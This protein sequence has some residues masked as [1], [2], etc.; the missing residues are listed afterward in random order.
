ME[1]V[2]TDKALIEQSDYILSIVPPRDAFSVACRMKNGLQNAKRQ[3][4][5]PLY[6]LD[7][8]A[9]SPLTAQMIAKELSTSHGV[10][11]LDG[12]IIGGPPK[13]NMPSDT[14]TSWYRPSIVVSGEKRL[15]DAPVSG[16][17]L[18]DILNVKHVADKIGPASGL[19]MCFASMNKGF[20]AIAIEAFTAAE[21]MGVL[22]E[23]QAHLKEYS[24]GLGAA[25]AKSLVG[26]P[27]KAYRWVAEMEEIAVT[28]EKFGGFKSRTKAVQG[29][30]E[31]T[32]RAEGG[33]GE[34]TARGSGGDL[35]RGVSDVYRFVAEDT[36]L[37]NEKTESRTKGQTPEDVARLC[38]K[39]LDGQRL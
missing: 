11:L 12:G 20:T 15:Q 29:T 30:Q 39:E 13:S 35:F 27:P 14:Y 6:F 37:G 21:N 2:P 9:V 8:N 34:A 17:H 19:K 22:P 23:L 5:T 1:L 16:S 32:V 26:M 38:A 10:C 36:E 25:A 24:P 31:D 7:L 33:P 3:K 18:A 28:M 4:D